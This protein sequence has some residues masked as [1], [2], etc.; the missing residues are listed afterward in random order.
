[1][2]APV[3]PPQIAIAKLGSS[4][5]GLAVLTWTYPWHARLLEIPREV[6]SV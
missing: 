3:K 4:Q 2:F 6:G 1:M 5:S